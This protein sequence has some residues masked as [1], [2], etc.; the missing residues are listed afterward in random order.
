[1]ATLS[2]VLPDFT[3]ERLSAPDAA[4]LYLE[5]PTEPLHVGAVMV[6]EGSDFDVRRPMRHVR[7]SCGAC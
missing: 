4:F 5:R 7:R 2:A 3:A 1:M 6:L